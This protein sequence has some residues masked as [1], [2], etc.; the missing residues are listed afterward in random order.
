MVKLA[1]AIE[2]IERLENR[3]FTDHPEWADVKQGVLFHQWMVSVSSKFTRRGLCYKLYAAN[4][5]QAAAKGFTTAIVEC[6]GKYSLA[7]ALKAGYVEHN[8][9]M[10][11][12]FEF[13]GTKPFS[14]S[15]RDTGHAYCMCV[16]YTRFEVIA[17]MYL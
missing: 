6:S 15:E 14:N 1:P 3:L 17:C 12:D 9:I 16:V 5:E 7:A 4:L 2:L 11:T 10:Y 13:N 8:R